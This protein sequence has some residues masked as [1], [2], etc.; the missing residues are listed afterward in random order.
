MYANMRAGDGFDMQ[1]HTQ[2][3]QQLKASA[4]S[5][6]QQRITSTLD[7]LQ[8]AAHALKLQQQQQDGKD[9]SM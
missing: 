8:D 7:T 1:A 3:L 2:L 9:S 6:V 5:A 4:P